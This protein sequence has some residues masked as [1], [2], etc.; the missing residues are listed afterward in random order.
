MKKKLLGLFTCSVLLLLVACGGNGGNSASKSSEK[1]TDSTSSD[2]TKLV[3]GASPSPHAEILEHVKPLLA[4]KGIDLEIK[5]FTDYTLPNTAL[6]ENEIDANYFQHIPFFDEAVET[7]GYDFANAGGIHIE[8]MAL[9]SKKIDK[10][11]ELEDGATIITSNSKTDWGRVIGI[12][13]DADLVKV[14]DGVKIENATFDDIA[15][16]KKNLKFV[17]E[18]DPAMLV[19]AYD[20]EE[21]DLV[22]I[23]TNFAVDAGLNPLNDSVLL[24][25]DNSPYVNIIAVRSDDKNND[26]I[27]TLVDTLHEKDVQDWILEEWKG[28]VKP[29]DK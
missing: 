4:K 18:I 21:G 17:H 14:K 15:E 11:S 7:N 5:T 1:S 8:P 29:V 16:N 24:E 25:S 27:K 19:T 26:A 10:I 20:N 9:Y 2:T 22:A 13:Q 23:N 12:L 6:A 3:V 28:Y